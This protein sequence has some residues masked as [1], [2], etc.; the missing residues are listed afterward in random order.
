MYVYLSAPTINPLLVRTNGESFSPSSTIHE[1]SSVIND[2]NTSSLSNNDPLNALIDAA[3]RG[4]VKSVEDYG[5]I[6]LEHTKKLIQVK[7]S[8]RT[9]RRRKRMFV[10]IQT[11]QTACLMS[12]QTDGAKL[13]RLAIMQIEDHSVQ[14]V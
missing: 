3:H 9:Y 7:R 4:N 8:R 2:E 14:V 1:D 5:N 13:V 11:A 6:F 12:N 10:S